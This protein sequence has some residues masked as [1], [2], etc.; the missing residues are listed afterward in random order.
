[1]GVWLMVTTLGATVAGCSNKL[2]DPAQ[3]GRF[4][5]TP[6]VN[7]ILDSL[8]VAEETP[9]AWKTADEPR[10]QDLV[11]VKGDYTL[12]TGDLVRISIFELFQE[13]ATMVNDYVVSETGK[14][15]IP[16][17]GVIQAA[18]LT[19]TQL[20]QEIRQ[21]L[22]PAIL[23]EPSV[24]VAL[25]NS[26]QR[27]F[28]ILG[29]G[30]PQ[31]GRYGIPRYDF[32]LTDALATAGGPMQFNVSHI[33]VARAQD[34]TSVA[35][36]TT[37]AAPN[38][39]ELE[40]VAPRSSW[41][42]PLPGPT[43]PPQ[44]QPSLT[45]PQGNIPVP[46]QP[47]EKFELQR[48]ML[49][50]I[51]PS[52]GSRWPT[53]QSPVSPTRGPSQQESISA[54]VVPPS[55][56]LLV[57]EKPVV[58]NTPGSGDILISPTEFGPSGPGANATNQAGPNGKVEWVF[59]NGKWVAISTESGQE[60]ASQ[61]TAP[62]EPRPPGSLPQ[63][64]AGPQTPTGEIEW[65][66]QDGKWVPVPKGQVPTVAKPAAPAKPSAPETLPMDAEWQE[67]VQTRLMK[68]PA[69]KLL[70]GDQRYNIVVKPGD[71]I[72]VPV[73][74]IGEFCIMG[75]VNR[76][77]FIGLTGRPMTLKMAIAAA[78]GL[79]PL[80]YPKYC[81][82]VRRLGGDR[83]EI[84]MVDLDKIASGEQPDF[85]IKPNDLINVGTHPTS[86]WRAA[87]RNAFRAAYGFAFVYD[88]NFAYQDD[89]YGTSIF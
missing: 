36:T 40:L 39:N 19:E 85:Y 54:S 51:A 70:A 72:Y 83:E 68:I 50:L 88:R 44:Q 64:T 63:A 45:V 42:E 34:T 6:A 4:R 55:Y 10:P 41:D 25:M 74:M 3:I 84:V 77:G 75:N 1:M 69:D 48:E 86:R 79:G 9:V 60:T 24:T 46:S 38:A 61:A 58:E 78:G 23:K 28:S 30:V 32:R 17:V 16:E 11:A 13:G 87:L 49:D 82:V 56:R 15:S 57:P 31:P 33:F 2:L 26:Q 5:P 62:Q 12:R 37:P 67:A 73:D 35:P 76:A 18:G 7:V 65:V 8:G 53:D 81:E 66:L 22:S 52:A 43:A 14:I 20:E 80:A 89:Y 21:S 47:A 59:R 71:T 27:T 29:N